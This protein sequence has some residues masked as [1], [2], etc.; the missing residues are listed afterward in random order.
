MKEK[1]KNQKQQLFY[2]SFGKKLH[3]EKT[4]HTNNERK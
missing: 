2:A 1:Q 3:E 4:D